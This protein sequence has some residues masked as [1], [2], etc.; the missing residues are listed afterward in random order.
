MA[1]LSTLAIVKTPQKPFMATGILRMLEYNGFALLVLFP[2]PCGAWAA[3]EARCEFQLDW[4][5]VVVA[6]V[7]I[8]AALAL[9]GCV[10]LA[11]G[12]LIAKHH[13]KS[14]GYHDIEN[15]A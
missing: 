10:F 4:W 8:A 12:S 3:Y 11:L 7:S 6:G 1:Q 5:S 14:L 9:V 13:I 2:I 15:D